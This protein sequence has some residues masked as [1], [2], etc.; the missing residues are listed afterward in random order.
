[1]EFQGH[2]GKT[3]FGNS[4]GKGK[5]NIEA[6]CGMVWIFSG[7]VKYSNLILPIA[8]LISALTARTV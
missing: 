4:E 7:S 2:G 8:V 1:M 5:L 3:Y 6:I